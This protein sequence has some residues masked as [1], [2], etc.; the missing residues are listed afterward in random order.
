VFQTT[1]GGEFRI[2]SDG[3]VSVGTDVSMGEGSINVTDNF[4][5]NGVP[6]SGGSGTITNLGNTRNATSV[7][8]TNTGGTDTT[9]AAATSSQAGVM[10]AVQKTELDDY[11]DVFNVQ[12]T[13]VQVDRDWDV[14]GVMSAQGLSIDA[15]APTL[16]WNDTGSGSLPNFRMQVTT[17]NIL[18]VFGYDGS[19]TSN[20][21]FRW[22]KSSGT[23]LDVDSF[24]AYG[25]AIFIGTMMGQI[26][27]YMTLNEREAMVDMLEAQG[28]LTNARATQIK[29]KLATDVASMTGAGVTTQIN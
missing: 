4:Y 2:A 22:N 21:H 24:G 25:G 18:Y 15:S 10:T 27:S 8:I 5:I 11:A 13:F 14:L 23:S 20:K 12:S 17:G 19:S 7:T 29:A 9:L 6:I 3:G 16:N 1:T 28:V 26:G